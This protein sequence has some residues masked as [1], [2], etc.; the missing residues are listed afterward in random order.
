[1]HDPSDANEIPDGASP[2]WLTS[3]SWAGWRSPR[4]LLLSALLLIV[5]VG[6]FSLSK[7]RNAPSPLAE[8]TSDGTATAKSV[9]DLVVSMQPIQQRLAASG[10][11]IAADLLPILPKTTGLQ[12][13]QVLVDE[14]DTVTA[15]QVLVTLDR[16]VITSQ[17]Q[18]QQAEIAKA[19][20]AVKQ[21][22]AAQ[23]QARANLSE[24]ASNLKRFQALAAKGAISR[25]ELETRSTTFL[26]AQEAVRLAEA[27]IQSARANVLSQRAR[28]EQLKIQL[29]QTQVRAPAGGLIAERIARI[30]NL[31]TSSEPLFRLIRD[32]Q[33][34][35]EVNLPETQLGQIRPGT[36][37]E[38]TSD[39]D[40]TLKVR[41]R[42]KR[43]APLIDPESRQA[44]LKIDL[45]SSSRLQPGMFLRAALAV[46]N[47]LSVVVPSAAIVPQPGG[48]NLVFQLDGDNRAVAR[49]VELGEVLNPDAETTKIEIRSGLQ[50]GDRIVVTGARYLNDGDIVRVVQ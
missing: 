14:G 49:P 16:S 9:T 37:V 15:G 22:Q 46:S 45:P 42:L 21:E 17:V 43:I 35:L 27:N 18:Q 31:T 44:R 36:A 32:R 24:A 34:E 4:M 30:G 2:S 19:Q 7:T 29:E 1:M 13:E 23:M 40:S 20:A 39:S 10:S 41:G 12:I 26:N 47:R 28:L 5:G 11:V 3:L 38:I 25:Q 50:A 8:P 6:G 48:G 33:L